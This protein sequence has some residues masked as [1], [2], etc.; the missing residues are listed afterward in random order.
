MAPKSRR[1]VGD[2]AIGAGETGRN[3]SLFSPV[4]VDILLDLKRPGPIEIHMG[5]GPN[6]GY[7]DQMERRLRQR[8]RAFQSIFQR[9]DD[10]GANAEAT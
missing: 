4:T 1:G 5:Q 7:G 10:K 3:L 9:L 8:L 2:G 6:P